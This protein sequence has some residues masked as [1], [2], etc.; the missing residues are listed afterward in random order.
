MADAAV[1]SAGVG[2]TFVVMIGAGLVLETGAA[3]V[4]IVVLLAGIGLM[5]WG[6]LTAGA[7]ARDPAAAPLPSTA[8]PVEGSERK[9]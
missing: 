3:W 2:G 6:S 5:L 4:G 7:D 1:R 9:L 8:V